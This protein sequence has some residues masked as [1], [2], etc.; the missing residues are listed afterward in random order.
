LS[1]LA[2]LVVL[3]IGVGTLT[4]YGLGI[5]LHVNHLLIGNQT[6]ALARPSPLTALGLSF[7]AG[8]LLLFDVRATARVRLSEWLLLCAA[9]TA[10]VGLTGIVLETPPLYRLTRPS[11]VG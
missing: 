7:L 4:E 5:D 8:A 3:A 2:A 11:F 1:T 6:I 9:F 10:L